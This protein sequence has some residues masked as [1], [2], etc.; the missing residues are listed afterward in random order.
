MPHEVLPRGLLTRPATLEDA[1]AI[2]AINLEHELAM[3][4]SSE[5]TPADVLEWWQ[6]E[7]V[8]RSDD[9]LVVTTGDGTLLGYTGVA[10]TNRGVMLDANMEVHMMYRD[11]PIASY[12]LSFSE[13]R[14]RALLS[15]HPNIPHLLYAW[16]FTPDTT[17]LFE[18]YGFKVEESDYRM[19]II[20]DAPPQ[21]PQPLK[22]ITIRT[23]IPGKEERAVYDVIAEAFPDI[24]G[25]P[26]RPYDEWYHNVFVKSTSFEPS[27]LYVAEA[28][29]QIVGTILCRIWEESGD[30]HIWQVAV[31]RTWR[32]RGIA[33]NLLYTAFNG[34]YQRGVHKVILDVASTNATGAQEL[35]KRAGM[36]VRSQTDYMTKSLV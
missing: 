33:L 16:S 25:E 17:Q 4:G 22:D 18:Q 35:Y 34:Y 20:F 1:Q 2:A 5:S 6:E 24:D 36:H 21:T 13:E 7:K 15:T 9:T 19:L 11:T 12:L 28:D 14:A 8:N 32:K 27:M 26:Y 30:G 23:F 10:A 29:S 31:R 3:L